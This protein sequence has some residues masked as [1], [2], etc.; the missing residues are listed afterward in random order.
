MDQTLPDWFPS[1]ALLESHLPTS[2]HLVD[3]VDLHARKNY[4]NGFYFWSIGC[5]MKELPYEFLFSFA[6]TVRLKIIFEIAE[7]N[8]DCKSFCNEVRSSQ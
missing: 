3:P 4:H 7:A 1:L 8:K 6:S 5:I 2:I